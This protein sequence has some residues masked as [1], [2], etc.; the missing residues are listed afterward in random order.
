MQVTIARQLELPPAHQTTNVVNIGVTVLD[1]DNITV[2]QRDIFF[3]DVGAL[4]RAEPDGDLDDMAALDRGIEVLE[5]LL[6]D[7]IRVT[8]ARMT[9]SERD[10]GTALTINRG[11]RDR[12]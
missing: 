11:W 3:A 10:F 2:I 5:S 6:P 1:K 12:I 9:S 4:T 7:G 8:H